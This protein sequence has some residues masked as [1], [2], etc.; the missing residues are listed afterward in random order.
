MNWPRRKWVEA[1][2]GSPEVRAKIFMKVRGLGGGV[3]MVDK[4]NVGGR[5]MQIWGGDGRSLFPERMG[6]KGWG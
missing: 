5:R 3:W 4:E 2:V 1:R 6:L